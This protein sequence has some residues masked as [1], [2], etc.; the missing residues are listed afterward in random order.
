MEDPIHNSINT[1]NKYVNKKKN[2]YQYPM[3]EIPIHN[4]INTVN[5]YVNKQKNQMP[6]RRKGHAKLYKIK[7]KN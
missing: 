4:N 7:I 5:R 6:I 2:Q 1:V 3:E